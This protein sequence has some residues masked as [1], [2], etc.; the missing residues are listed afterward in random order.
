M[1]QTYKKY[2]KGYIYVAFYF[3]L[4]HYIV[5]LIRRTMR[6][7]DSEKFYKKLGKQVR[8]LRKD[9]NLSQRELGL[10]SDLEKSVIQRLERGA[11]N[12]TLKTLIKVANALDI[13][14]KD[15]FDF[16]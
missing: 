6:Y 4:S 9:N 1:R 11:V 5:L 14:F 10:R 8:S 13:E 16:D 3:S 12:S 15:L 2:S 7:P